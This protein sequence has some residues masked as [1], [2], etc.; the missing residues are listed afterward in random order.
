MLFNN[1]HFSQITEDALFI[2]LGGFPKINF[3][4][5]TLLNL[6]N[7]PDGQ[8][9]STTFHFSARLFKTLIRSFRKFPRS[10]E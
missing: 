1:V 7:L 9:C 8:R 4:D 3:F 5:S 6:L 2:E 10:D